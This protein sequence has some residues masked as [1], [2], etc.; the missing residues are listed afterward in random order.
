[1]LKILTMIKL[2]T[3]HTIE[4]GWATTRTIPGWCLIEYT[5]LDVSNNLAG[6]Q[7]LPRLLLSVVHSLVLGVEQVTEVGVAAVHMLGHE[8]H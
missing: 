1:M 4:F 2:L 6:M 8:Y 7:N 3:Q 5:V